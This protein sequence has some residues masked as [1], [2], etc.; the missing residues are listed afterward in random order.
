MA[1]SLG[2][3]NFGVSADMTNLQRSITT[4]QNFGRVVDQ[5]AAAQSNLESTLRKQEKAAVDAAIR[6]QNLGAQFSRLKGSEG[7]V[8]ATQAAFDSFNK[9]MTSG[10]LSSLEYQRAQERLRVSLANTQR[11][12]KAFAA[13]QVRGENGAGRFA[14]SLRNLQ[15]AAVI[16]TGPLGG[17]ATRISAFSSVVSSSGLVMSA[18]IAGIA[19]GATA[20]YKLGSATAEVGAQFIKY[21][22]SLK[23]VTGSTSE[24]TKELNRAIQ[25]ANDA[26]VSI[27]S[28]TPAY[29]KFTAAAEGTALQGAKSQKVFNNV[30]KAASIM[31]LSGE[32]TA[33]VFKA[34]EQMIS[35]G[36][37]QAEELR[38]QL[39]DRLPGAFQIAAR[40]MDVSTAK[41]GDMMK[42]GLVPTTEF[43]PKFADELA[44][45]FNIDNKP[46]DTYTAA[47]NR[48][49]N[50]WTLL[51]NKINTRFDITGKIQAA[52]EALT[53]SLQY[54]SANLEKVIAYTAILGSAL[55]TLT[56]G[57]LGFPVLAAAVYKFGQEIKLASDAAGTL[58][59]AF[60]Y[61]FQDIKNGL[62]NLNLEYGITD[63]ISRAF[64]GG[65]S[66][67]KPYLD[68][69]KAQW[70]DFIAAF[71]ESFNGLITATQQVFAGLA[72]M[73]PTLPA[74][75]ADGVVQ[76]INYM[77]EKVNAGLQIISSGVNSFIGGLNSV[78]TSLGGTAINYKVD[79]KLNEVDN[80]YK[81]SGKKAAD[82]FY[83]GFNSV[84]PKDY[85]DATFGE[86]NRKIRAGAEATQKYIDSVRQRADARA[87]GRNYVNDMVNQVKERTAATEAQNNALQ[88][89]ARLEENLKRFGDGSDTGAGGK[90]S[91]GAAAKAERKLQAIKDINEAIQRAQEEIDA[92]GGGQAGIKALN[93]EFKRRDE[94]EEYAKALRKAGADAGF[95]KDKTE[96]LY[97]LLKQRDQLKQ[98]QQGITEWSNAMAKSVDFFGSSLVDL[99]FDGKDAFKSIADSAKNLA[100][101]LVN[102]FIQLSLVNPLKNAIFGQANPV[103]GT[104][105]I[106]G[107]LFGGFMGGGFKANTTLSSILG[108][109]GLANGGVSFGGFSKAANGIVNSPTMFS[110]S[111]G[112]VQAGEAGSEAI[113]PLQRNA[114]GDL[115]VRATV[116]NSGNVQVNV[117]APEGSSVKKKQTTNSSGDSVIDIIIEQAKSAVAGDIA[118]G[119]TALSK[120]ISSRFGLKESGGLTK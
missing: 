79:I 70:N 50:E 20:L 22:A 33:G 97:N 6:I 82:A 114:S 17:V 23:A 83:S 102:T 46:I 28:L 30:A 73:F 65:S 52:A 93:E 96:E 7:Y 88:R 111:M 63:A 51:L 41:L 58:G 71:P 26:G 3:I 35:K 55:L 9:T 45:T 42:K 24:A 113:M 44:K 37:V 100:K 76:A 92:V 34:L 48:L 107:S 104:G 95:I 40:A 12:F 90:A 43:L 8:K 78:I 115:G 39:G 67:M 99:A 49:G 89:Q 53:T 13:A 25:I 108:Y 72:E 27:D 29:T 94:V 15:A 103:M 4:L 75:I 11:E 64:S 112:V 5:A 106:L 59:D 57:G 54:V 98:A 86:A 77:I 10:A 18:W 38:G 80:K 91:K 19:L 68:I 69:M 109:T 31:G 66:A 36:T 47:L 110:G 105:G 32:E 118:N 16:T 117:Y 84:K 14:T 61:V 1:I 87:S 62:T 56:T 120:A 85:F 21:N 2:D 74:A 60:F 101:D 116:P 119:G 81:N